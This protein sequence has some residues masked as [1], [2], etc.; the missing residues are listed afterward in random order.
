[1]GFRNSFPVHGR[2]CSC[3]YVPFL[4]RWFDCCDLGAMVAP[5]A[6]YLQ[7]GKDDPINGLGGLENVV[8][9]VADTQKAYALAGGEGKLVH[10]IV[11]G[12][13]QPLTDAAIDFIKAN[14]PV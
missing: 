9:Q 13:A 14:M 3:T 7:T 2:G 8:G 11:E 1:M 4:W 6:M 10:N 5:K 12:G